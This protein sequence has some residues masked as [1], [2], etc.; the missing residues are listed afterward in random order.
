MEREGFVRL[1]NKKEKKR[2]RKNNKGMVRNK[3]QAM[4]GERRIF[5]TAKERRKGEEGKIKTKNKRIVK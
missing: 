3:R 4:H 1:Q 5:K 2:R